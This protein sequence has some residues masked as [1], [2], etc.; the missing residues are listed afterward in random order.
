MIVTRSSRENAFDVVRSYN[1]GFTIRDAEKMQRH[2]EEVYAH[3][4]PE[5]TI[6]RPPIIFPISIRPVP[7]VTK[8]S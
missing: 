7:L 8:G 6:E 2:L 1:L 4:V 3:G 5:L